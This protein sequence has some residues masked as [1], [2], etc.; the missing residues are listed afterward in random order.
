MQEIASYSSGTDGG[1][2]GVPFAGTELG[3][4]FRLGLDCAGLAGAVFIVTAMTQAGHW[5]PRPVSEC[6]PPQRGHRICGLILAHSGAT[7]AQATALRS[8]IEPCNPYSRIR[9]PEIAG[10]RRNSWFPCVA[11]AREWPK[12]TTCHVRRTLTV[13]PTRERKGPN[14]KPEIRG[15]IE[16]RNPK[17]EIPKRG[18]GLRNSD[19]GGWRRVVLSR[20]ARTAGGGHCNLDKAAA[21]SILGVATVGWREAVRL[22]RIGA[23]AEGGRQGR[24]ARVLGCRGCRD[25]GQAGTKRGTKK[26]ETSKEHPRNML[27]TSLQPWG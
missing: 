26:P 19:L 27:A 8:E 13:P 22:D 14:P 20:Y 6:Q 7:A 10:N 2:G 15:P 18:F 9:R 24:R 11:A 3:P 23:R 16:G 5:P 1:A 4:D 21:V 25:R 17:P 12:R